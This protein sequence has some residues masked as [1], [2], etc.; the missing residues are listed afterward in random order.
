MVVLAA[1]AGWTETKLAV[2]SGGALTLVVM[3]SLNAATLPGSMIVNGKWRGGDASLWPLGAILLGVG[4]TVGLALVAQAT[5][6]VKR[7]RSS[8]HKF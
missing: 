1:V 5:E 4:A 8:L 3:F 6:T 2:V 7:R